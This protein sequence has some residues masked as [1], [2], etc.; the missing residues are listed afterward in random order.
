LTEPRTDRRALAALVF[1]AAVIGLAPILVRL[2]ATGPAAAGFWRLAFALP[3][4]ALITTRADRGPGAPP[5]AALA[6]GAMFALDMGFWHYGLHYTSVANATVLTNLTPVVV[7][8]VAWAAFGQRPRLGFVA[9]VALAVAGAWLMA[10]ARG[11]KPGSDPQLG[12][13]LSVTTALWY[14]LYMIAVGLARRR[15]GASRVMLWST[16]VS[17]P[18]LLVAALVM[19]ERLVPATAAGW[20]ACVGLGLVHVAGQGTIAWSL[21]RLPTALA[22]VVVLIQPLVAALL[23]WL[24]FAES[25]GP[26]RALGGAVALTGVVLAQRAAGPPTGPAAQSAAKP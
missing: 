12:D 4:L 14:A 16:L 3:L 23:G 2:T 19:G 26:L 18:L 20:A 7:S 9:A 22:S 17:A 8:F 1:G 25:L 11:G 10:V 15:T 21:G 13:A 5:R 6:A 24:L